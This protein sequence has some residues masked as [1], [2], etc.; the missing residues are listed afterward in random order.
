MSKSELTE[1]ASF[2][3]GSLKSVV[4]LTVIWQ[5]GKSVK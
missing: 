2:H 1:F 5:H 4:I 3:L